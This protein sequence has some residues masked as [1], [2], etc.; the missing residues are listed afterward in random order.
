MGRLKDSKH[1]G[2][3]DLF[4]NDLYAL[5]ILLKFTNGLIYKILNNDSDSVKDILVTPEELA[6]NQDM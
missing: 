6:L 4:Y 2:L 1:K 3:V 5:S